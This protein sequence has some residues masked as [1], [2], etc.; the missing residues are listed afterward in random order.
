MIYYYAFINDT[1]LNCDM[2]KVFNQHSGICWINSALMAMFFD[3]N[4][5][6]YTWSLFKYGRKGIYDGDN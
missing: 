3:D 5:K 6:K 1:Y 4:I 2:I